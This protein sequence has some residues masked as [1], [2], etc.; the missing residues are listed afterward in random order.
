MLRRLEGAG[1]ASSRAVVQSDRPDKQVFS[2]TRDGARAFTAWLETPGFELD[3]GRSTVLLKLF[4]ARRARPETTVALLE[5]YL[6]AVEATLAEYRAVERRIT[7]HDEDFY[8]YL[9]LK[10]GLAH[11]EASAPLA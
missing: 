2:V 6:E 10:L 1:L 9:T 8:G 4:F 5:G 3:P 11:A 7:G